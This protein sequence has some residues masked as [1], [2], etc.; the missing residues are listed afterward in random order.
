MKKVLIIAYYWPPSGGSG[1]QRWLKFSKYLPTF[2][3]QPIIYTPENPD[4]SIQDLSL[5]KDIPK[6]ATVLKRPIWEPYSWYKKFLK[7]SKAKVSNS[8]VVDTNS[9]SF[10]NYIANWI[11]GN[12]FIPDP[13]VYWVKPSVKY[14]KEYLKQNRIDVIISTGT[15]HSMHLIPLALCKELDIP[16][17]ADFRDPWSQLDMLDNYHITKSNK[18]KYQELERAV[19]K[20]ADVSITTSWTWAN[21]F[22]KLG[23]NRV[24]TITNGY[25]A[26]DFRQTSI[27]SEKFVISHFGLMNHLRS[28]KQFFNALDEASKMNASLLEDLEIHLGGTIDPNIRKEIESYQELKDK[29]VFYDYLSHPEVIQWYHKS[30]ILLLLLFNSE[31]G[32]GNIPGKVFEYLAT[33]KPIIAFGPHKGDA[34]QIMEETSNSYF[35]YDQVDIISLKENILSIYEDW[36]SGKESENKEDIESY[37]RENLSRQLV[38]ILEE[39]T[40]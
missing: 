9:K 5:E 30:S 21:D 11:R 6:E 33:Q 35:E 17:I 26:S 8:G 10:F 12:I 4:F 19:L 18:K 28:P 39:I 29:V 25:D 3:W 36:K 24:E 23:A 40:S 37:S 16:W 22:K 13:K 20:S 32:K 38:S 7:S 14:L 15:P 34:Y 1:V 31:S 2:N 27:K